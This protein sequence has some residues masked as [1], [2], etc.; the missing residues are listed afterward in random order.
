MPQISRNTSEFKLFAPYLP[1]AHNHGIGTRAAA[2]L[3]VNIDPYPEMDEGDL[4]ELFWDGCYVASK[5][6]SE[7]DIGYTIVLRVPESFLQ[8]GTIKTHYR[9][10]K[11][12]GT[13]ITSPSRK[14]RVK[15]DVPGGQLLIPSD[16]ENQGLAPVSLPEAIT[17]HGLISRYVKTGVPLAIEP[18][19]NMA[20]SDE[21]TLR[22]GDLR[23]D[24]APLKAEDVGKPVNLIVPA[25]LIQEAGHEQQLEVT[26]CIIDR[27]GNN[28]RWA[29]V[30]AINFSVRCDSCR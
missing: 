30:R 11:V 9:V 5:L 29:P 24:L 14:L 23:M 12:G 22:W 21:I 18:Y 20:P 1:Q 4:I 2:H 26:Y 15:L 8:S 6:L 17:R 28:S 16:E 13:P 27:V 3:L 19:L 10:M 7:S 25:K